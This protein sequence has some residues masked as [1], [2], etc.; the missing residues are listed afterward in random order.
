MLQNGSTIPFDQQPF[1]ILF[2]EDNSD[3]EAL[4]K[5]RLPAWIANLENSSSPQLLLKKEAIA[6]F[7][8]WRVDHQYVQLSREDFSNLNLSGGKFH[9]IYFTESILTAAILND[10]DL[11]KAILIRANLENAAFENAVLKGAN[12]SEANLENSNFKRADLSS[13]IM[14]RANLSGSTF[15]D[16]NVSGLTI[17]SETFK[18]YEHY[19]KEASNFP[20]IVIESG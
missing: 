14:L 10:A 18:K 20:S 9:D 13:S 16:A 8:I 6:K 1:R 4:L 12:L 19:L 3:G 11:T 17:D 15:Q 5:D 2:Y 7:N